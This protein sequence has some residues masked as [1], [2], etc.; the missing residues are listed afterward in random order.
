[1]QGWGSKGFM[2]CLTVLVYILSALPFE[3]GPLASMLLRIT[4]VKTSLVAANY[5]SLFM[6]DQRGTLA[7]KLFYTASMKGRARKYVRK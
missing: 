6:E 3:I 7:Y 2:H 1:M 4:A 5:A